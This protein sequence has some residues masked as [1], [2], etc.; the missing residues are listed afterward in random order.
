[1][2]NLNFHSQNL[3]HPD[4]NLQADDDANTRFDIKSRAV[5]GS[6]LG[7]KVPQ[8]VSQCN[9]RKVQS[10]ARPFRRKRVFTEGSRRSTNIS[11]H[12]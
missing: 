3:R 5:C 12:V 7:G 2:A 9:S 10:F 4:P 8:G 11:G 1:M 6:P